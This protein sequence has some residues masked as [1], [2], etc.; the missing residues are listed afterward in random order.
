VRDLPV[1]DSFQAFGP[2]EGPAKVSFDIEWRATGATTAVGQGTDV[3]PT[4]PGAFQG[5]H[6][7][8]VSSG[9]FSGVGVGVGFEVSGQAEPGRGYAEIVRERDGV[10]LRER[11]A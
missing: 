9:I 10:F 7:E 1:I 8:A 6:A 3:P 11:S 5:Q 4:D 2:F